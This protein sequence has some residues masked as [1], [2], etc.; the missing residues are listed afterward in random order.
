MS[1]PKSEK[2]YAAMAARRG[3]ACNQYT[4]AEKLGLPKPELSDETRQKLAT[5]KGRKHTDE[6]KL[7]I[8]ESM[9]L[10][11]KEGRAWNLGNN[12]WNNEPS[13]PEKFFM[14]VIDNEMINK[15]YEYNLYFHGF[16]LDFAW[17]DLKKCIEIDGKQHLESIQQIERDKRKNLLLEEHGWELLRISWKDMFNDSKFYI[18]LCKEF[19]DH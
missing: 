10:A 6:A 11:H 3:N 7:K 12:R 17:V 19:I 16:W 1:K 13:Y 5:F 8:S 15:N 18:K 14:E 4:K 2:W 9:K